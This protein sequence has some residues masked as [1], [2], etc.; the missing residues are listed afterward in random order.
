MPGEVGVG[1]DEGVVVGVVVGVDV[2]V[3][4]DVALITGDWVVVGKGV[5]VADVQAISSP[6]RTGKT[7]VRMFIFLTSHRL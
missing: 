6:D 7:N 1:V 4:E 3:G 2:L 5:G